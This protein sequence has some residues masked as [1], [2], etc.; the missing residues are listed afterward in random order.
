VTKVVELLKPQYIWN[1]NQWRIT[2]AKVLQQ[3]HSCPC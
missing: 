1:G 3:T 2:T